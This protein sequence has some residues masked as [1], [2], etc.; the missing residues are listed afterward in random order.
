M[1]GTSLTARAVATS[2]VA[3]S[4]LWHLVGLFD[5]HLDDGVAQEYKD[6]PL[7]QDWARVAKVVEECGEAIQELIAVTGQNPRKGKSGSLGLLLDELADTA[8]TALYAIQH[9]TKDEHTTRMIVENKAIYHGM[10]VGILT[11]VPNE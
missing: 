3:R 1:K 8:L 7:A 10:R 5:Q 4:S 9:F 2:E 6:Q 11:D